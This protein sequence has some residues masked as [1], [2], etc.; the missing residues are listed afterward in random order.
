M[1]TGAGHDDVITHAVLLRTHAD[2]TMAASITLMHHSF[3]MMGRA[4]TAVTVS[5][6]LYEELVAA[7]DRLSASFKQIVR[8]RDADTQQSLTKAAD[9]H[10]AMATLMDAGTAMSEDKR[11]N[12]HLV[13]TSIASLD[14]LAQSMDGD[15]VRLCV[16]VSTL[17]STT[18]AGMSTVWRELPDGAVS[19]LSGLVVV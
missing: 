13:F 10:E 2:C 6:D 4:G 11:V 9:D 3:V 16:P 18:L 7:A 14:K 19:A 1:L 12:V 5:R 15:I 17:T 8:A